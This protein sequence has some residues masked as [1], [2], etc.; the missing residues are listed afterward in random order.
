MIG[1]RLRF[2][3]SMLPMDSHGGNVMRGRCRIS[4]FVAS[5]LLAG[6]VVATPALARD[7]D[8]DR[9][10]G[11]RDVRGGNGKIHTFDAPQLIVSSGTT[12]NG[13]CTAVCGAQQA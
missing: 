6:V 9:C 1:C 10:A 4:F 7:G 13:K 5:W 2:A 3:G 11:A 8:G 12:K